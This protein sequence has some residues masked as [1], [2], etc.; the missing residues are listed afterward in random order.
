MD[1]LLYVV[2]SFGYILLFQL[3][4]NMETEM[5]FNFLLMVGVFVLGGVIGWFFSAYE[6][7]F[8]VAMVM[9]YI[10]L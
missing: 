1:L 2:C 4:L 8:T 9:S 3:A 7:G 10:F 5:Y 6:I